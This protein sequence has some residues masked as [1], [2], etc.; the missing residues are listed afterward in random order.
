MGNIDILTT[1]S[2]PVHEHRWS[3]HLFLSSLIPFSLVVVSIK[4]FNCLVKFITRDFIC[5]HAI[6]NEI[7]SSL[8]CSLIVYRKNLIFYADSVSCNFALFTGYSIFAESFRFS[9]YKI[10]LSAEIILFFPF[11]FACY[12]FMLNCSV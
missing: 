6:I 9:T 5:L 1:L 11:R 3:F 8:D 10:M 12:L 7:V 2:L 4:S